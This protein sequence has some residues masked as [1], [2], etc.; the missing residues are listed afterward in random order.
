MKTIKKITTIMTIILLSQVNYTVANE[1]EEEDPK[2]ET[3]E[4]VISYY[5]RTKE[6]NEYIIRHEM[7]NLLDEY[8]D[9][10]AGQEENYTK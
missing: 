3:I 8:Y 6:A 2:L 5:G 1:K 10:L 4:D 7:G 9:S